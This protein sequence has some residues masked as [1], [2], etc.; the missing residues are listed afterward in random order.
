[1]LEVG[2]AGEL[3]ELAKRSDPT[4][5]AV[6]IDSLEAV[7]KFVASLALPARA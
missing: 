7:E 4:C 3:A 5:T 6:A 2:V 1:M